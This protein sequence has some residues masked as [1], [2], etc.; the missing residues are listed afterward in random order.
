MKRITILERVYSV[1]E[2]NTWLTKNDR[3][4]FFDLTDLKLNEKLNELNETKTRNKYSIIQDFHLKN[5]SDRK[6][7]MLY[8]ITTKIDSIPLEL[9]KLKH[10]FIEVLTEFM[11]G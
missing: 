3:L 5:A 9:R 2:R 10:G 4:V 7:L 1:K 11:E 8:I 6:T